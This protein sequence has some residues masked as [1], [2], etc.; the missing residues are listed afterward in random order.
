MRQGTLFSHSL[1]V[2]FVAIMAT[3]LV[4]AGGGSAAAQSGTPTAAPN[5]GAL[6]DPLADGGYPRGALNFDQ[7]TVLGPASPD[8]T[9]NWA[10]GQLCTGGQTCLTGDFNGDGRDDVAVATRN[11]QGAVNVA[12]S[13]GVS[14]NAATSWGQ[15]ICTGSQV[16]KVGDVNADGLGDIVMFNRGAPGAPGTGNVLVAL[17]QRTGFL[18]PALWADYFCINDETCAVADVDGRDGADI[19]TFTQG[20]SGKVYVSRS[21][22][23]HFGATETWHN[24][25][26]IA[27]QECQVA[28]VT[29][30][31]LADAI[32]FV[33][34]GGGKGRVTVSPS[35]GT[36][37]VGANNWADYFCVNNEQCATGDFD[38]NGIQDLLT[39]L[40][41]G[42]DAATAGDVYV[43]LS[44]GTGLTGSQLWN[45]N[46]CYPNQDCA[47]GDFNGDGRDD[48]VSFVKYA[49]DSTLGQANV[50]LATG[51]PTGF[52]P[53]PGAQ[54]LTGF[55]QTTGFGTN[56]GATTCQ[57]GDV[58]GDGLD[59]AIYFTRNQTATPG[60]VWV[61]LSNG[62]GFAPASQPWNTDDF[63][64][65]FY[66]V[67]RLGDVN[68]DGK[69]DLI[70]FSRQ[71]QEGVVFVERSNGSSFG[72]LEVW[73]GYFCYGS[74]WCDVG[75]YNGDGLTDVAAFTRAS[76]GS[77]SPVDV[78]LSNGGSFVYAGIWHNYFCTAGEWCES[79][80][81]NGDGKDDIITFA[82]SSGKV[83]VELSLGYQFGDR[84]APADQWQNFFCPGTEICDVGDFNG[85]G[86]D[87]IISFLR[88]D[89]PNNQVTY[90]DVY[91]GL[92]QGS[93]GA[94]GFIS[95]KW[96][97]YFCI[98]QETCATG[99]VNADNKKDIVA[100][101]RGASAYVYVSLAKVGTPYAFV[102][103]FPPL[104]Q[105]KML[106]NLFIRRR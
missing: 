81:V 25:F 31:H 51:S 73:N 39:F 82:K 8:A 67:C 46:F 41:E 7:P 62:A 35:N 103:S 77:T 72:P 24:Y 48:V 11:A 71:T 50:A 66:D 57:T 38:G 9:N 27:G 96:N 68:A 56:P 63:C 4:L 74:Q 84:Q 94:G 52:D 33:K 75:D 89:Y 83:Y 26:C 42:Y 90:G 22:R 54:W 40:R 53:T 14:F 65:G 20:T 106:L 21:N 58:N 60:K 79:A 64:S 6:A 12:L 18:A 80:D 43:N 92:S 70:E 104:V 19:I 3:S 69:D 2:L 15:S 86:K 100:F 30:D 85:D 98:S 88:S 49:G 59:D 37:F 1:T 36:S 99:Y 5:T 76:S 55:C 47:T 93:A 91:V 17:S 78:A 34:T 95:Q 101:T 97:E 13:N 32:L 29:G 61:A 87:D 102:E 10:Q 23:F 16:C 105:N 28:D 44:V 45:G